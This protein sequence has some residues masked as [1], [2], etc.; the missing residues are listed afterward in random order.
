L[1]PLGAPLTA[2][3]VEVLTLAAA[4][5][6]TARIGAELGIAP[7]TV[8][9]HFR[10]I[11]AKLGAGGR[12]EAI[13]IAVGRRLLP[14]VKVRNPSRSPQASAPVVGTKPHRSSPGSPATAGRTPARNPQTPPLGTDR[15]RFGPVITL[16]A[17]LVDGMLAVVRAAAG[18]PANSPQ[19]GHARLVLMQVRE[20]SRSHRSAT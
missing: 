15:Q 2:R 13:A 1:P 14:A 10:R 6:S 4:S 12:A 3:E 7:C 5:Y 19:R 17:R 18:T 20:Y 8:K 9:A 16:P 11:Y